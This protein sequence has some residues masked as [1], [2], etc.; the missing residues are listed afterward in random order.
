MLKK[1]RRHITRDE[2][3]DLIRAIRQEV[4]GIHLRTTLMVGHPGETEDD[5]DE[6]MAFVR[7]IRFERLGAFAYS[8]EA[9][10]YSWKHY[11]D[12]IPEK[13]KQRRLD[14]LMLVQQSIAL[15]KNEEKVGQTLKVIIDRKENGFYIGRTEFDSP[16]VDPEALIKSDKNLM[17]GDFYDVFI[18]KA[19]PFEIYGKTADS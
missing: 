6:L 7:K 1:M 15:E 10:T 19:D 18:E 14:T 3:Y 8:H 5:F 12:E 13:T 9:G 11:P 4:P 16:E 17:I 2:T